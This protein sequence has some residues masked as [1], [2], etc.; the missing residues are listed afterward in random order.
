MSGISPYTTMPEVTAL[1]SNA[2]D[3]STWWRQIR[4]LTRLRQRGAPAHIVRAPRYREAEIPE[5]T[6]ILVISSWVIGAGDEADFAAWLTGQKRQHGRTIVYDLDDDVITEEYDDWMLRSGMANGL[7]RAPREVRETRNWMIHMSDAVTVANHQLRELVLSRFTK[8]VWIVPNAIDAA[9]LRTALVRPYRERGSIIVGWAGGQRPGKDLEGMLG[10]WERL[11]RRR[12]EVRFVMAGWAPHDLSQYVPSGR[13]TLWP[14]QS[15]PHY[16]RGM[17]VDIGCCSVQ[18][19]PFNR[20]KTPIK[21]WEYALA[22]AAVIGTTALYGRTVSDGGGLTANT[23]EEWHSA[24][25]YYCL[26]PAARRRDAAELKRK[27]YAHATLARNL[28]RTATTYN[29]IEKGHE[30]GKMRN[31]P[32]LQTERG[33]PESAAGVRA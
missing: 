27:V 6:R 13:T 19:I 14:W 20:M 15:P 2:N 33:E 21:A 23:P 8:P 29:E 26:D 30:N 17:A 22:G 4:P 32:R 9:E 25:E 28:R 3:G 1:V 18:D 11:S 5:G 31:D 16:I 10:G 24:L 7:D 12:P